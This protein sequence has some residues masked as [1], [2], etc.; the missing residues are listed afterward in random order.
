MHDAIAY[1]PYDLRVINQ[2]YAA[3]EFTSYELS[4]RHMRLTSYQS[5]ICGL[6]VIAYAPYDLR[7]INQTYAAYELSLMHPTSYQSD[8]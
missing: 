1:A 5:D 4:I 2:T 3:Y 7:V 8:I 6:R